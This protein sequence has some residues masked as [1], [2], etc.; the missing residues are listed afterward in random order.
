[1]LLDSLVHW[2]DRILMYKILEC[3]NWVIPCFYCR[4]TYREWYRHSKPGLDSTPL[5]YIV[6]ELH[7]FVNKKL[8]KTPFSRKEYEKKLDLNFFISAEQ[9]MVLNRVIFDVKITNETLYNTCFLIWRKKWI[10]TIREIVWKDDTMTMLRRCPIFENLP[11]SDEVLEL[12]DW[13]ADV[14]QGINDWFDFRTTSHQLRQQ[15]A[16]VDD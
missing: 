8:E 5:E 6:Y 14:V 1:M 15:N 3:M 4:T 16:T 7:D 13:S 11:S 12:I 9:L 10:H 2:N